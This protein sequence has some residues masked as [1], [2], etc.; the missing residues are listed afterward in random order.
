MNYPD[1]L[2]KKET[3]RIWKNIESSLK[4]TKSKA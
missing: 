1:Q 3:D 4:K 2:I